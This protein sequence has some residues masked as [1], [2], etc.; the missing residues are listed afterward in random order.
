MHVPIPPGVSVG[1]VDIYGDRYASA[2]FADGELVTVS[3]YATEAAEAAGIARNSA[4]SDVNKLLTGALFTVTVT[5]VDSGSGGI[6]FPES[7]ALLAQETGSQV[8]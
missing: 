3:T 1:S 6:S 7:P 2:S 5:G 8:K 4:P